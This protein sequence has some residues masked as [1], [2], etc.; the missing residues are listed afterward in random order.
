M[1]FWS[2]AVCSAAHGLSGRHGLLD[3]LWSFP[4][5]EFPFT[6][7]PQSKGGCLYQSVLLD[8]L[9]WFLSHAP[10]ATRKW[11]IGRIIRNQ[12]RGLHHFP[13]GNKT[14]PAYGAQSWMS[15]FQQT[16]FV[17]MQDVT[18]K[19]SCQSAKRIHSET[20]ILT[21]LTNTVDAL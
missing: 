16:F 18:P 21:L 17:C 11:L 14:S 2:S 1:V 5:L 3:S 12:W 8:Q 7:T 6:C 13:Q 4:S 10:Q 15:S 20:S 9:W 19:Y